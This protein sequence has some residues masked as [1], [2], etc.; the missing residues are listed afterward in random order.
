M[1]SDSTRIEYVKGGLKGF[2]AEF[3]LSTMPASLRSAD[4]GSDPSKM[5]ALVLQV[6]ELLPDLRDDFIQV[7]I[8]F[9]FHNS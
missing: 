1:D 2:T 4:G 5:L 3:G 7:D 8:A 6:K 9:S